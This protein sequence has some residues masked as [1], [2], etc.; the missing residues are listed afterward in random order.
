MNRIDRKNRHPDDND[1]L[2]AFSI[3]GWMAFI[4]VGLIGS[5]ME[6]ML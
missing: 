5:A 4:A 1:W 2:I 3:W 6:A